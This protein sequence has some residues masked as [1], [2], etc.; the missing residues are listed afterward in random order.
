MNCRHAA[1][2][3]AAAV[4]GELRPLQALSL[5][6]H[7]ARCPACAQQQASLRALRERVQAEV[8]RHTAPPEFRAR[9][10]ATLDAAAADAPRRP[11]PAEGRWRWLLGGA[12][13]GCAATVT[14]WFVATAVI[15]GRAGE[16]LAVE[17][18]N[19]HVRATLGSQLIQVAS[20]DQHTVKPWLS[21]H[22]DYSPPV[23][24]YAADGFELVG[25][26]IDY[27]DRHPV[28]TLVYRYRLHNIDVFVR[29]QTAHGGAAPLRSLRGF[30]L[31]RGDAADME[32][33]AVS[34]VAPDVLATLVERIVK[35]AAGP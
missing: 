5:R 24:D 20:S 17:A 10:A 12:L 25:G 1:L 21:A 23:R 14:A 16:N 35:D 33:I 26:R 18:V 9:L 30:N 7:V 28:A 34:D 29:P 27:L 8:P 19:V 31:V 3:V 6:R 13:A 15:D 2:L 22:L 32:W 11:R 4:D